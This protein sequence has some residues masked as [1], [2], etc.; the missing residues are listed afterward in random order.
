MDRDTVRF[1]LYVVVGIV[2]FFMLLR[3]VAAE[4]LFY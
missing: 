2:G 3:W 1:L 4:Y